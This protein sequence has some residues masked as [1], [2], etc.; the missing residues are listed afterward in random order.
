MLV[1]TLQPRATKYAHQLRLAVTASLFLLFMHAS[2]SQA[3]TGFSPSFSFTVNKT[4]GIPAVVTLT[5]NTTGSNRN[6]AKY[7]WKVNNKIIGTATGLNT[8]KYTQT[9][10]DTLYFKLVATDTGSTPCKDS[11]TQMVV[12]TTGL[13]KILDGTGLYTYKPQWKNC[14]SISTLPDTF[15]IFLEVADSLRNYKILWGDGGQDSGTLL[16]NTGKIY[17]KYNNLG[18]FTVSIISVT[19]TCADTLYGEVI[20]EKNP[21]ASLIGPPSGTNQGCAPLK[22]RFINN[23]SSASYLTKFTWNM[24]DSMTYIWDAGKNKDTLYHTYLKKNRC[25]L[26]VSLK[27]ENQCGSSTTTW[28]PISVIGKNTAALSVNNP[29]NCDLSRPFEFNNLSVDQ[30]CINPGSRRFKWV[31]GDGT[32]T[33]WITTR[34]TLRKYYKK[35]GTYTILLIDSNSCGRD[36]AK[37]ILKID[38]IIKAKIGFRSSVSN[39]CAPAKVDFVDLSKGFKTSRG[40]NF[41]NPSGSGNTS[42]DSLPSHTYNNGG[43]YMIVLTI[44]NVCGISRDTARIRVRARTRAGFQPIPDFCAPDSVAFINT[45]QEYFKSG[46]TY[47]WTLPDGSSSNLKSPPKM[48]ISKTGNYSVRLITSDSCGNDTINRSFRIDTLPFV[49]AAI[50]GSVNNLCVPQTIQFVDLS[51]S[52]KTS[53]NWDFGDPA[54]GSNTST[55]SLPAHTYTKGGNYKVVL[56][57]SNKCGTRADTLRIRLRERGKAGFQKI[58]DFCAPDSAA[59]INTSQEWFNGSTSYLWYLPDGTTST[60]KNPGKM[61]LSKIGSY[62][63]KLFLTDSC[64]T[65]SAIQ[66]FRVDTIPRVKAGYTG[67][68]TDLCVPHTVQFI[69]LS[70]PFKTSRSWNFGDPGASGNTSTDS[71]PSFTYTKGGNYTVV[72]TVANGCGTRRDTLRVKTGERVKPSFAKINDF[73]AP[74]SVSFINTSTDWFKTSTTYEWTLPDGSV[75]YLKNPGKMYISKIGIYKVKLRAWDSCGIDSFQQTFKVDSIPFVRAGYSGTLID[76]CSPHTVQF[77]DRTKAFKTSRG[78]NFGN[79]S[80]SGNTSSDSLPSHTY[81]QGGN[82]TVV[83]TISNTCGTRRDTIRISMRQKVK[84]GFQN[85]PGGCSP[86][87]ASFVN[88]STE[89]FSTGTTYK[90][91]FPDGSTSSATNPVSKTYTQGTYTVKLVAYDSCGT[92]TFERTF[93]VNPRPVINTSVLSAALCRKNPVIFRHTTNAFTNSITW[94]YGDGKPNGSFTGDTSKTHNHTFDSAKTYTQTLFIADAIGCRDTFSFNITIREL[95]TPAF[96]QDKT[97]GCGPLSVKFTNNSTHNGGGT[98]SQLTFRWNYGQNKISVGTD[99][100]ITY[101]ASLTKDTTYPVKL[102]VTNSFGCRDSTSSQVIVRADPTSLFSLSQSSGCTPLTVS[103]TNQSFPNGSGTI[104]NLTFN[105]SVSGTPAATKRDTTAIFPGSKTKDSFYTI[106]LIVTSVYGCKDTSVRTIQVFP[107]PL[108]AFTPSVTQ[109]CRPLSVAFTNNSK[110]FDTGSIAIMSFQWNLGNSV[111]SNLSDPSTVYNDILNNDTTYRIRLISISEHGCRDTSTNNITLHPSPVVKFT[112]NRTSGCSVLPVQFSNQSINGFRWSWNLGNGT[113]DTSRQPQAF[114]R[115]VALKDTTY[116][117]KLTSTS[118]HGCIGDSAFVNITVLAKPVA[119]F[120]VAKDTVCLK[121]AIQFLNESKGEMTHRWDFGNGNTSTL[122]NPVQLFSKSSNPFKDTGYNVRLIATAINACTDTARRRITVLPF[123]VPKFTV[124][125]VSGCSPVT[126]NFTSASSNVSRYLWNF[127]DGYTSTSANVSHQYVNNGAQDSSFKVLLTTFF[128]D[129]QDTVSKYI[130]VKRIPKAI[131]TWDPLALCDTNVQFRHTSINTSSVKYFFGDGSSST[132]PSPR[133]GYRTSP[134]RDTLYQTIFIAFN[135]NGCTDTVRKNILIPRKL[136]VGMK[137]TSYVFCPPSRVQFTNLTRGGNSYFWDFGDGLGS[138]AFAP[139]HEYSKPGTYRYKLTAYGN[140]GCRDSMLSAGT[141]LVRDRPAADFGFNP[142]KLKRPSNITA[143]FTDK[144]ISS[145]ALSWN[146]NFNDPAGTPP[147]SSIQNPS[148]T[149]SD[150]GWFKIRLIVTNGICADTA[151]KPIYVEPETP[152]ADFDQD[153][154]KGCSP[155]TV[156]F[157]NKS[158]FADQ[159]V[160][161]FGDG[162]SG[163]KNKNVVTHTFFNSDTFT[164]TLVATGAGGSSSKVKQALIVVL[165]NPLANFDL[166]ARKVYLPYDTIRTINNS[167]DDSFRTWYK[168]NSSF[169]LLEQVNQVK[170]TNFGFGAIGNYTIRLIVANEYGCLDTADQT[171]SVEPEGRIIIPNAF[172]PNDKGGNEVFKA[173]GYSV[174]NFKMTIYSRWGQKLYETDDINK[175]W[176][177]TFNGKPCQEG[178]Y[179]YMI[180]GYFESGKKLSSSCECVNCDKRHCGHGTF[181]LFR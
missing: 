152:V 102:I 73:C 124:N 179:V 122:D 67:P 149:F 178:V 41:G 92:D 101:T 44:G 16:T 114:F 123:P 150:T 106:R 84:A 91:I 13:P 14:I 119:A 157:T 8:I 88:T 135:T 110:P 155:L 164:V 49:K 85:I 24:G 104:A 94:Q 132:F 77:I 127:G 165:P 69:D 51:K 28:N 154:V 139:S 86:Y 156:T 109:G 133:H 118:V 121:T 83:L 18:V 68:L 115:G 177:G 76:L 120:N 145:S 45:S 117:V 48:Y 3:C 29:R 1:K 99:S 40:W 108:S 125:S 64:G 71:L 174:A 160:W 176:D 6:V 36:T 57:I 4:C 9:L 143:N 134:V 42:T 138:T 173:E 34:T 61:Y 52:V 47:S 168:Y 98:F 75:S 30:N 39:L 43:N 78:W 100:A 170:N 128:N 105:W 35:A 26:T 27:A 142:G 136:D 141:I 146:W 72:L 166:S 65:D 181:H 15:G 144:S 171:L 80:G 112:P 175:G 95:P 89:W 63:V 140:N 90:W 62:K 59:F 116:R 147:T 113:A 148:H 97:S 66:N 130:Q 22:V 167:R 19:G 87:T 70:T 158:L 53:R 31:W 137:D 93:V 58:N 12:I 50:L 38:T 169:T 161:Y 20:N 153:I 126:V 10:A 21:V 56:S 107:K 25:N 162:T 172:T 82:Y 129:C 180:D 79:P 17:H 151:E 5:N 11:V 159:W 54:S 2:E 111:T 96:S 32:D 37:Y 7:V 60:L 81:T 55:D 163:V 74:D 23:S 46:I 33:G 131:Y 103:T